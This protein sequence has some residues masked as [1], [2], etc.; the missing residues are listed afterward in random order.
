MATLAQT[1]PVLLSRGRNHDQDRGN[2]KAGSACRR[3]RT[4]HQPL[5]IYITRVCLVTI[6]GVVESAWNHP[7]AFLV[8]PRQ[9]TRSGPGLP[10]VYV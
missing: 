5:S 1:A 3:R 10:S 8:Y 2:D 9:S 6:W 7:Q 4:Q